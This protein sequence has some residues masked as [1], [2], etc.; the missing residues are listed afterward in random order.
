MTLKDLIENNPA[1][2]ALS[3]LFFGFMSGIGTYDA[4][5]RIAHL[6]TV[7]SSDLKERDQTIDGLN[8]ETV[9]SSQKIHDLTIDNK[10]LSYQVKDETRLLSNA[11]LAQLDGTWVNQNTETSGITRFQIQQR[12]NDIF[13]HA[14]GKCH[15]TDCDWGETRALVDKDSAIVLWDQSFV[16]RKMSIRLNKRAN[17]IADYISIFTDNSGRPKY[18]NVETFVY[19]AGD[20]TTPS[21]PAPSPSL[22]PK[23]TTSP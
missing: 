5:L 3:L 20:T 9:E 14:W 19:Q 1:L 22:P 8:K 6:E 21:G 7:S 10:N 15:P 13:V 17:M 2:V 16:F 11:A 12:G 18:E 23:G 4:I